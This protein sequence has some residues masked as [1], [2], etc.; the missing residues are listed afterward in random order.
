MMFQIEEISTTIDIDSGVLHTR[1]VNEDSQEQLR[2][3]V[4]NTII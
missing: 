3:P 1:T 4:I 2:L